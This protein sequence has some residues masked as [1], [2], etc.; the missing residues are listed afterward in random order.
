MRLAIE[1]SLTLPDE[2]TEPDVQP[3]LGIA[4]IMMD[5]EDATGLPG[6]G[7]VHFLCR[8]RAASRGL[9]GLSLRKGDAEMLSAITQH[10]GKCSRAEAGV[11]SW[12]PHCQSGFFLKKKPTSQIDAN[13]HLPGF[14]S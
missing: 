11:L 2:A 13:S 12:D 7:S 3:L 8:C 6:C 5:A 1:A 4:A 10:Q 14:C 9:C